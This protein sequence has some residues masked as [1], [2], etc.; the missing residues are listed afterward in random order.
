MLQHETK[1]DT[2]RIQINRPDHLFNRHKD[3]H[4]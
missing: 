3:A 1:S 4:M 2:S